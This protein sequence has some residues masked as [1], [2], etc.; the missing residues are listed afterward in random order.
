M[1]QLCNKQLGLRNVG[2]QSEPNVDFCH[3]PD[4]QRTEFGSSLV[5]RSVVSTFG[6]FPASNESEW[7]KSVL[8]LHNMDNLRYSLSGSGCSTAVECTPHDREVVGLNPT[9]W[10]LFS[11]HY[12]ISSASLIQVPQA[13]ATLMIF[14]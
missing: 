1:L 3:D 8:E 13:G 14:L 10:R 6:S 11:L 2:Y 12:P 4:L 5:Q 9:G 7:M